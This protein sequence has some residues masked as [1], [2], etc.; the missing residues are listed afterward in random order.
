MDCNLI[1]KERRIHALRS[2]QGKSSL[3]QW[4]SRKMEWMWNNPLYISVSQQSSRMK[5]FLK[6]A[7]RGAIMFSLF[8]QCALL[9]STRMKC[10]PQ[11]KEL[12]EWLNRSPSLP[13]FPPF[14]HPVGQRVGRGKMT[15]GFQ[16]QIDAKKP[17]SRKNPLT[18]I[19]T[20]SPTKWVCAGEEKQGSGRMAIFA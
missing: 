9:R 7:G 20:Q 18:E 13:L 4:N 19:P 2:L 8:T 5:A 10:P 15:A 11:W 17:D 6:A 3:Q 16:N 1:G 12:R 14:S